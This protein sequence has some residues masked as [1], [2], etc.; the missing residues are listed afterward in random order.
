MNRYKSDAL[1]LKSPAHLKAIEETLHSLR[2]QIVRHSVY[3]CIETLEE[4][5]VFVEHHVFAV[6]DFMSLLKA[7]QKALT[8]VT[9]PWLPRGD[10]LSRRL[11]NEIVLIEESDEIAELGGYMSHFE[12]YLEGMQQCGAHTSCVQTFLRALEQGADVCM[13]LETAAVPSAA[14]A[15]VKTTWQII[16]T[17][18]PHMIAAAFTLGRED[19]IPDMFRSMVNNLEAKFPGQLT[20]FRNY[21]ERHIAVDEEEHTPMAFR[22]L[23]ELCGESADRWR[24][25]QEAA[26][27]ALQARLAL[28]N[29]IKKQLMSNLAVR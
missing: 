6:W 25:A 1:S 11:I 20:L 19:V 17:N 26:Q 12:L 8:S 29:G 9:V 28:W 4:L 27:L 5:R 16:E 7:L 21:L 18:Q 10:R 22:M 2:E 23:E 3:P 15:F 24:Q 14:Q 13:A